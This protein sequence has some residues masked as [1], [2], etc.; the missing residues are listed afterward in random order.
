VMG[1]S[2]PRSARDR[3]A[4]AESTPSATLAP[5]SGKDGIERFAW[6]RR[7]PTSRLRR[8]SPVQ[9]STRSPRAGEAVEGLQP[10]AHRHPQPRNLGEARVT[11]AA[12]ALRPS[13]SPARQMPRRWHTFFSVPRA[14]RHVRSLLE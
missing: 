10:P 12:R 5:S 2:T 7:T 3:G 4:R 9:V 14:P 1:I 6:A 13:D 8:Q 11:S